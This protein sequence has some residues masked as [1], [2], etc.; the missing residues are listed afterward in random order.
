MHRSHIRVL[1]GLGLLLSGRPAAGQATEGPQAPVAGPAEK[2]KNTLRWQTNDIDSRGFDVY[3]GESQSGPFS[4]LTPQPIDGRVRGSRGE[5]A[6]VDDTIE[7][8]KVYW[9]YVEVIDVVG[10]RR[11][12]TPVMKAAA[13]GLAAR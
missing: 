2:L 5:F 3:R 11:K 12:L 13:K 4:K 8:G 7:A 10:V 9:Y 1:L 6:Y